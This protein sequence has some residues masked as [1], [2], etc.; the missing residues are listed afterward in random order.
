VQAEA[1]H[2]PFAI[3]AARTARAAMRERE[4]TKS[5]SALTLTERVKRLEVLMEV[6]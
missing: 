1:T 5:P 3:K 6:E 4:R 2:N